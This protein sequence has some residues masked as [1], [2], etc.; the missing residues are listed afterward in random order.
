MASNQKNSASAMEIDRLAVQLAKN[1]HSKV[2]LPLAEEYCKAGMWQEAAG[3]LEDGLKFYPGFITAMVVLGR[4]YDQLGQAT[5]AKALLEE[6]VKLSPENLRAHRTLIKIYMA[7]G[8]T[9]AAVKSCDVIL[10][11]NPRD[12]EALSARAKLGLPAKDL[13]KPQKKLA[14]VRSISSA[15]NPRSIESIP[16]DEPVAQVEALADSPEAEA[17]AGSPMAAAGTIIEAALQAEDPK[18]PGEN[19]SSDPLPGKTISTTQSSPHAE[20]IAQLESWLRSIQR[21]RRDRNTSGEPSSSN[22]Q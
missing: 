16:P 18:L 20:T 21:E 14:P 10:G 13:P 15:G 5:K 4:A 17:A 9:E 19:V 12:E 7:Q 6:A 2:F 8:L 22:S 3:V 11:L 1:P